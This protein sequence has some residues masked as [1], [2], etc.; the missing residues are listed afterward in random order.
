M[1]FLFLR[2]DLRYFEYSNQE[3]PDRS[4]PSSVIKGRHH[5]LLTVLH[6]YKTELHPER[7]AAGYNG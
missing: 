6:T 7:A 1:I 3:L 5:F 4:F 2:E